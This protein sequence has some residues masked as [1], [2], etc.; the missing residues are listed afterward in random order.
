MEK[1]RNYNI[2]IFDSGFGGL[3]ILK[4]IKTVLP[5]YNYIYLGD[6]ARA[7]YGTRSFETV[8]KYTLQA[9]KKLFELDCKLIIIACNTAS[10]KAL[11]SIQQNDLKDIA[12]DKRVLGVIRPCTEQANMLTKTNNLGIF[13]TKGTVIS[14]SYDIEIHKFFPEI[15]VTSQ[16]CPM[17]VPIIEN[18]E[19]NS[20]GANYFVKKEIQNI[21][22]QNPKIDNVL[23]ACTH[24]PILI[25]KIK[26]FLPSNISI[27]NQGDIVAKSL[28]K[29]L[30]NHPEIENEISKEGQRTYYTTDSLENFNNI[31]STFLNEKIESLKIS[32]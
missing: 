17:W 32:L 9:V 29:Y 25:D 21:L 23:L 19:A 1:K 24:Y 12:P 8:Y 3:S 31:G 13:A 7:P 5:E 18:G 30:L 26:Q 27:T 10:A 14:K 15:K 20:E 11:R 2:G 28:Q 16:A 4:E 22:N 6:N